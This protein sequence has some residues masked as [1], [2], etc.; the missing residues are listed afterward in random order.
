M[1][2]PQIQFPVLKDHVQEDI[3]FVSGSK[4][5]WLAICG[6]VHMNT[7]AQRGQKRAPDTMELELQE[8]V[9]YLLWALNIYALH[10]G[11]NIVSSFILFYSPWHSIFAYGFLLHGIVSSSTS[12]SLFDFLP[13]RA[14]PWHFW[15]KDS[16]LARHESHHITC[17]HS[18]IMSLR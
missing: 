11:A 18:Q 12:H 3:Y 1:L 10:C 15:F 8:V 6:D 7:G 16:T 5:V 4:F 17:P 2:K 9:S 13:R 14:H